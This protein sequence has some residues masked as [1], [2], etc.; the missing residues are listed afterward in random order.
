MLQIKFFTGGAL[1]SCLGVVEISP[2]NLQRKSLSSEILNPHLQCHPPCTSL[3]SSREIGGILDFGIKPYHLLMGDK[4]NLL[5]NS[6]FSLPSD[7][8]MKENTLSPGLIQ[9]SNKLY[10]LEGILVSLLLD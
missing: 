3:P 9:P 4:V 10:K 1:P 2:T 6:R 8:Q 5:R 7:S